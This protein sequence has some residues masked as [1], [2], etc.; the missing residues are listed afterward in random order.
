MRMGF[1]TYPVGWH[2]VA[3]FVLLSA[4][5]CS[6]HI[7]NC[8]D[9]SVRIPVKCRISTDTVCAGRRRPTTVHH[10]EHNSVETF[11]VI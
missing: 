9:H 8:C 1:F 2:D 7:S 10:K 3:L 5:Q 6:I 11:G 4:L